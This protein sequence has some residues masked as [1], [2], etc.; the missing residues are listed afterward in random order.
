MRRELVISAGLVVVTLL[1]YWPVHSFDFVVYDD[2]TYVYENTHIRNGLNGPDLRWALT[3]NVSSHWHPLTL[4]SHQ[5]DVTLF[6][7][8]GGGHHAVNL[9]FHAA[10]SLLVFWLFR[11]MSGAVWPS[12]MV[13]ALFA[14]HPLNVESVAW[15]AE[16]KNVLS[17]FLALLT[18]IAYS[19]YAQKPGTWRYSLVLVLFALGLTAKSMLVTLPCVMLLLDVWPLERLKLAWAGDASNGGEAGESDDRAKR[20]AK[21]GKRTTD[22][23]NKAPQRESAASPAFWLTAR[24]LVLEKIP[25]FALSAVTSVITVITMQNTMSSMASVG[26]GL[27]I[28]TV[29]LAYA[30]YLGK[31][32]WP[33]DLAIPYP[34]DHAPDVRLVLLAFVVLAA[35]SA[36]AVWTLQSGRLYFSVGWCWYLG[37]MVP[38]IGI[39]HVGIQGM[40]DRFAYIP[41]IGVFV[42]F[43]WGAA[44]I[45]QCWRVRPTIVAVIAGTMLF[46]FFLRTRDQ[47]QYWQNSETLF[48]HT[49]AVMPQ[50]W[51]AHT[52][53]VAWY[54]QQNRSEEAIVEAEEVLRIAPDDADAQAYLALVAIQ[55]NRWDDAAR[56]VE[57]ALK[58][59]PS[60]AAAHNHYG[61]VLYHQGKTKD[62]LD[63]FRQSVQLNPDE[64]RARANLARAE[65]ASGNW[66]E[67]AEQWQ[68]VLRKDPRSAEAA[69]GLGD[70]LQHQGLQAEAEK[71]HRQAVEIDT[72][73]IESHHKLAMALLASGKTADAIKQWREALRLQPDNIGILNNVAWIEATASDP[74]VRNGKES[75]EYAEKAARLTDNQS[76]NV[77]DSLAAAYAECGRFSEAAAAAMTAAELAD[78]AKQ[79]E[80]A[81]QIRQRATL[82]QA[83]KPYREPMP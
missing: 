76:F 20:L 82:Y 18:L 38:V 35:I 6:G 3:A 69:G 15:I 23:R 1:A 75:L 11:R 58:T 42:M 68:E 25:F 8:Q 72:K 30:G 28:A 70:A 9:A 65:A 33:F 78:A 14:L 80:Q 37:T 22:G 73:N 71:Y 61:V 54:S 44:D 32:F 34:L 63:H 27:R 2:G 17:T 31:M 62:A 36:L 26:L 48:R 50:N 56:R 77:L 81:A 79:T 53:L 4:L 83:G 64:P 51:A 46:G 57:I 59:S 67:A 49:L 21:N 12:A 66:Q 40:A 29:L 43:V 7:L 55:Q 16:R 47:V 45:I 24:R 60:N 19:G 52:N 13:A 74:S 10:N 39:V 41:L 5:V